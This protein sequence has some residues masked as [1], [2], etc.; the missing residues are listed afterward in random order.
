M[1]E[2]PRVTLARQMLVKYRKSSGKARA[3]VALESGL[4]RHWIEKFEQEVLRN[5]QSRT[6]DRLIAYLAAAEQSK[7]AA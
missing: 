6:L 1:D 3:Q 4:S 7:A 5:P 2:S